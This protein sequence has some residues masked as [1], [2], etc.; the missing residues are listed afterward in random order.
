MNEYLDKFRDDI[1]EMMSRWYNDVE[2]LMTSTL[3]TMGATEENI[4][5]Y[6]LELQN[7]MIGVIKNKMFGVLE[8]EG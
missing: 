4:D 7:V 2:E 5:E 3:T 8:E 6:Y 1:E